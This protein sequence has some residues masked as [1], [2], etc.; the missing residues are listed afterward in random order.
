[1]G[2]IHKTNHD[3]FRKIDTEQKAY[4]LGLLYA[5]G[6]VTEPKGNRQGKVSISLQEEDGYILENFSDLTSM[7]VQYVHPK[8][9][10]DKG[11]KGRATLRAVSDQIY[12]D[13][14]K[15]GCY[16]N[17]SR[18]GM[19]FPDIPKELQKHFIRGFLDGD[20]SIIFKTVKYKYKRKSSYLLKYVPNEVNFK[21]RIAFCSTDK[22]FLETIGKILNVKYYLA[23]RTRVQDV[24]ILWIENKADVFKTIEYLYEDSTIFL[25]R[26]YDKVKEYN[27]AIKSQAE[28]RLSE[29][30]ETTCE[31][32]FS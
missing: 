4:F 22:V 28:S 13:L 30:L 20:G 3:Y 23:K 7:S 9:V 27:K 29:G 10:K 8:S 1:M 15:L 12:A 17:K 14:V 32:D 31:I 26:K 16:V 21:L 19:K 24:F 18:L 6:C 5:D 25:K 11:W 2:Y